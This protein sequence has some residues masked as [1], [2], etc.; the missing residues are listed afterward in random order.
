MKV[1]ISINDD[2]LKRVDKYAKDNYLS[3]SAVITMSLNQYLLSYDMV[4]LIQ[5]MDI[6]M[7]KIADTGKIDDD[8]LRQLEDFENFAKQFVG[9]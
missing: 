2:L 1:Q 4:T 3:R 9:K 6:S 5:D 7:R 8:S